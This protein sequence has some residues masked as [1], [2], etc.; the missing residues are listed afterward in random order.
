MGAI[1]RQNFDIL[2]LCRKTPNKRGS[3]RTALYY[4]PILTPHPFQEKFKMIPFH[5]N[6][7]R[8]MQT[9]TGLSL[10][11]GDPVAKILIVAFTLLLP[12]LAGATGALENP[13]P[14]SHESGIGVV[15]GWHCDAGKIDI[16]FDGATILAA[17]F[18]TSRADTQTTCGKSNT[19]FSLLI[20]WNDL[21]VGPHLVRALADGVEFGR[22][23][24]FVVPI[25][26]EFWQGKSGTVRLDNFPQA[27]KGVIAEWQQSKQNFVIREYL[28]AVPSI[29]GTWYGPVLEQWSGCSDPA[30]NGNHG[31]NAIWSVAMSDGFNLV[32]DGYI[33]TSPTFNC[34]YAGTHSL[35]GPQH[36]AAGTF[37][38]TNGKQGNWRT[39]DF[40]IADRGLSLIGDGNWTQQGVSCQMKFLIGGFRH[41][42]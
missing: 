14:D 11:P 9:C 19:G 15:S 27:G 7:L 1:A 21:G 5:A 40:Q 39:T 25:G 12:T 38:C 28:Q 8:L 33:Q 16:E 42:P 41:L 36:N 24:A 23:T 4:Q 29:N 35:I 34:L 18:G 6:P 13:Q 2:S 31:A 37:N 32:I 20:N 17:G 10:R 3:V 26:S 30:Y 22:A